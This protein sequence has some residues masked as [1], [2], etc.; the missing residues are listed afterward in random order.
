MEEVGFEGERA[1]QSRRVTTSFDDCE[2]VAKENLP[3]TK[4]VCDQMAEWIDTTCCHL[5]SKPPVEGDE[6]ERDLSMHRHH[7][8]LGAVTQRHVLTMNQSSKKMSIHDTKPIKREV[9]FEAPH[10]MLVSMNQHSSG[11]DRKGK[12]HAI[13]GARDS[14]GMVVNTTAPKHLEE[15][16]HKAIVEAL[17]GAATP[18]LVLAGESYGESYVGLPC[19]KASEMI[20]D[21]EARANFRRNM[22]RLGGLAG[23]R[24]G[25]LA[26]KRNGS[27]YHGLSTADRQANGRQGGL[28]GGPAGG[29]VRKNEDMFQLKNIKGMCYLKHHNR[30]K[31]RVLLMICW[32]FDTCDVLSSPQLFFCLALLVAKVQCQRRG[33]EKDICLLWHGNRD[34]D[35]GIDALP[36]CAQDEQCGFTRS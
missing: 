3:W 14:S 22:S 27:G 19:P 16:T 34:I 21:P 35:F 1:K 26:S 10:G 31:V 29:S 11:S 6:A 15:A 24:L 30:Y 5:H 4:A 20:I 18:Q 36:P 2:E 32:S 9:T 8:K 17:M 13:H 25:G 23:G 12:M 33:E 7:D 28:L